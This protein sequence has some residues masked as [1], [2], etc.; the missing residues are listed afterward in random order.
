[1]WQAENLSPYLIF[2]DKYWVGYDDTESI[3]QKVAV[4]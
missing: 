4:Y 2:G 1:M 3:Y